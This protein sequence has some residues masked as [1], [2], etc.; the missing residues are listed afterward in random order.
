LL[1]PTIP[2]T[3]RGAIRPASSFDATVVTLESVPILHNLLAIGTVAFFIRP[4]TGQILLE[5]AG[6]AALPILSQRIAI[7]A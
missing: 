6:I 2:A 4:Q 1:L 5:L 7:L 3:P